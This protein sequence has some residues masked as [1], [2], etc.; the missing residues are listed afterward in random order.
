MECLTN[1]FI[2][3][4]ILKGVLQARR[5]NLKWKVRDT[6]RNE[7]QQKAYNMN[8][9]KLLWDLKQRIKINENNDI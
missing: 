3:K 2:L 8:K 1:R 5:N 6:K 9:L 4:E 7:T